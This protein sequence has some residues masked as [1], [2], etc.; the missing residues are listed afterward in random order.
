MSPRWLAILLLLPATNSY[1]FQFPIEIFEYVDNAR[2]TVFINEGDID[3]S[4][5]WIPFK[6]APPLTIEQVTGSIQKY[7][8]GK[9]EYRNAKLEEIELRKIP[10]HE[11]QWHYMVKMKTTINDEP[12]NHYFVVLMNGKIISALIEPESIK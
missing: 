7:I 2:V 11:K 5:N 3:N 8:A 9:A 4:V 6:G 10:H 12:H 1:S